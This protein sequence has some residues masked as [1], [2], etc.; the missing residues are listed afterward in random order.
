MK[1][2]KTFF[3]CLLMTVLSIGQMWGAVESVTISPTQALNDG[4]V[5]P[6]T[7]ACAKGDGRS[8]STHSFLAAGPVLDQ[9]LKLMT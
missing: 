8:G 4:G 6:I 7:I 5:D 9:F 3:A 2:L 1:H